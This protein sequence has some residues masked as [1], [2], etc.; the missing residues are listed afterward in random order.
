MTLRVLS[1][2]ITKPRV[3]APSSVWDACFQSGRYQA[4]P[5]RQRGPVGDVFDRHGKAQAS[6]VF[7]VV[8]KVSDDVEE[9][10]DV[11]P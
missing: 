3:P 11:I 8:R 9:V 5:S 2:P 7:S 1:R 6:G 4:R 10:P